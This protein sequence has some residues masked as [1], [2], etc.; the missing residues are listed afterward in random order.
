MRIIAGKWKGHNLVSFQASH[1]RPT[2]DRVKESLFNIWQAEIQTA[3]VLDLFSGT[4]NLAIE[5]LSRGATEVVAVENHK[6]SL[7]IIQE[8][9][10]KLKITEG[11]SVRALDVFRFLKGYES[12]P[13]DLIL[14]DPPFTQAIAHDV[15]LALAKSKVYS[16]STRIAIE[17]S[18]HERLDQ[19]YG[20][21]ILETTKNYGDKNLSLFEVQNMKDEEEE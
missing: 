19:F 6:G 4:G 3:R 8:N 13:F 14:I 10:R 18:K 12:L 5:A 21:I 9:I 1:V 20:P 11:L 16:E 2:T 7:K 17:S 15:M